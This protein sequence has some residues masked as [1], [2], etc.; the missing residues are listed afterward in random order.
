[1]NPVTHRHIPLTGSAKDRRRLRRELKRAYP[2]TPL[3][4]IDAR[5]KRP[6][7]SFHGG[8]GQTR[9][10]ITTPGEE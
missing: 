8:R 9:A 4:A 7:L 2:D 6:Y 3:Q 5:P 1:M 10:M